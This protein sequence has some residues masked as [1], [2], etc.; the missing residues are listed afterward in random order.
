MIEEAY[1]FNYPRNLISSEG[2]DINK[3]YNKLNGTI[4]YDFGKSSSELLWI[5]IYVDN[6]IIEEAYNFNYFSNLIFSD[7][8]HINTKYEYIKLNCTIKDNLGKYMSIVG[9]LRL[10]SFTSK[11]ILFTR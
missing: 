5:E 4:K 6:K 3:K 9:K 1:N 2:I 7:G 10:Y 8:I 11:A